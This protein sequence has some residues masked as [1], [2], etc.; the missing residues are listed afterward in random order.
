MSQKIQSVNEACSLVKSKINEIKKETIV[1]SQYMNNFRHYYLVTSTGTKY[2]LMYKR[3]FFYSFGKIF[4]LKGAGESMN[5][6]FLRFALMNEIDEVIIAYE[7]GKIYSLSP[8]KWMAYCQ[9]NKTIRETTKGETTCS[10]PIGLL[11]R[12]ETE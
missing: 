11:E 3:D 6:E 5:K 1:K 4:N 2:Y 9:D 7:S 12:W 8:N 10:V